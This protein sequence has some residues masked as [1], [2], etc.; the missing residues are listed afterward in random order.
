MKITLDFET[1]CKIPLRKLG[2][3][4]YSLHP[5]TEVLCVSWKSKGTEVGQWRLGQEPPAA[6]FQ[7]VNAGDITEAHN[8]FFEY[9]IWLNVCHKRYGWP[10][11]PDAKWR[12]SAA[13]AA[14]CG[15]SRHLGKAGE[16][17]HLTEQK[18][19]T[20]RKAMLKL[21]RGVKMNDEGEWQEMLAYNRQDVVAE[22]CL[23]DNLPDLSPKEQHMWEV[24]ERMNRRGFPIDRKGVQAALTIIGAHTD[25]LL[26][27]FQKITGI[28]SPTQ[29]AKLIQWLVKNGLN[30]RDTRAET[31]DAI[32]AEGNSENYEVHRA[33]E[34]LRSIGRSSTAKYKAMLA[35]MDPYDYRVRGS[36]LYHGAGTGRWAGRMVQPHNF[37][38]GRI[39]NMERAWKLIH[40]ADVDAINLCE[41]DPMEFLSSALRGAI[42]APPGRDFLVADYASIEAR[43]TAWLAD[44]G[45]LID[46]FKNNGDAYIAMAESVYNRKL[47]KKDNPLERQLGKEAI[48]GL[49]FGMGYIKFLMRV[50]SY[51][52]TFTKEQV[53]AVVPTA[54]RLELA[55]EILNDWKRVKMTMP[56][57]QRSDLLDL[58][59][60]KYIVDHYRGKYEKIVR[61]W[62]NLEECAKL[63]VQYPGKVFKVNKTSWKADDRFL[64]CRLP[65]GRIMRYFQ[66]ELGSHGRLRYIAARGNTGVFGYMDT[67]GGKLTE[68][69][70]QAVAR[71]VMADA[72]IRLEE[73]PPYH[74]LIMTVH[75]ELV[76]EIDTNKGNLDEFT[77]LVA[78]VPDWAEG[79]PIGAESWR[80]VRYKK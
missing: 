78:A 30:V 26:A 41:W 61:M 34:I 19:E 2:M 62:G 17:L 42:C 59:F 44:E 4:A 33:L 13:K 76:C 25:R 55:K 79:M 15:I 3:W 6:L 67:Y 64:M 45:E 57:A 54:T 53:C 10:A 74:E 75:D 47:N 37:P 60:M 52:I 9:A 23:S 68:N 32:L 20:G 69:V 51:G 7:A 65:S 36:F 1:T 48:L 58:I 14:A 27:D 46:L 43:V 73:N 70:V 28:Q 35:T 22:E 38:K 29:R 56:T 71:D 63:A 49:G 21:S 39:K 18:D 40:Q 72:M 31:L 5:T 16:M 11:I 66:P 80:G 77:N 50:R 8:S 12:C 24:S